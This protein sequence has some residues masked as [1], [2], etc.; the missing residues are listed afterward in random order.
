MTEGL[1]NGN[2]R[3]NDVIVPRGFPVD[4][5]DDALNS[6]YQCAV[7]RLILRDPF[8]GTCGHR[9]CKD[10]VDHLL[11]GVRSVYKLWSLLWKVAL[12]VFDGWKGTLLVLSVTG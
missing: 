5:V 1:L 12:L 8:Q 2:K 7:C 11:L 3:H 10:C 6:K 4:I 9:F